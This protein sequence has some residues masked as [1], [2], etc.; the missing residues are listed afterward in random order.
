[1]MQTAYRSLLLAENFYAILDDFTRCYLLVGDKIALLIDTGVSG[2][3]L[4]GFCRTLTEQPIRVVNTHADPDHIA[5]N[6]QFDSFYLHPAEYN[7]AAQTGLSLD[8]AQPIWEGETFALKPWL[9]ETVLIPGHTPGGLALWE[10]NRGWLFTGDT[11]Q[12]GSI[13]LS[14]QGRSIPAFQASLA[15]LSCMQAGITRIYGGHGDLF[16]TPDYLDDLSEVTQAMLDG[17]LPGLEPDD[18]HL[19]RIGLKQYTNGRVSLL[20]LPE[21]VQRVSAL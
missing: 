18:P 4:Y 16:I 9:L 21:D 10:K 3:D 11:V 6:G 17:L 5:A 13:L 20:A 2:G 19:P 7:H 14:G 12:N 15:K 8:K 1:M